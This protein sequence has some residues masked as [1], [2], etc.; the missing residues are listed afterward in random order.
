MGV[1]VVTICQSRSSGTPTH[2]VLRSLSY[3]KDRLKRLQYHIGDYYALNRHAV[4]DC[5]HSR[6]HAACM[7]YVPL[8]GKLPIFPSGLKPEGRQP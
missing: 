3:I 5:W 1:K 2:V 8:Q 6:M 7:A 4:S